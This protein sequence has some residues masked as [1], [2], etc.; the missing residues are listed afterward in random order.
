M[1]LNTTGDFQWQYF[2]SDKNEDRFLQLLKKFWPF[3]CYADVP[4]CCHLLFPCTSTLAQKPLSIGDTIPGIW[5]ENVLNH[6][7][8][9]AKLS[10]CKGKHLILGF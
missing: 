1:W 9:E 7:S 5:F 10:D 4:F 6:L 3:H 2:L 8:A